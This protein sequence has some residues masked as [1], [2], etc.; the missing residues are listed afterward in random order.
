MAYR[1]PP[2]NSLRAFESAARHMSFKKAAEELN[3]TPA[4]VSHLVKGLEDFLGVRLFRRLTRALEL[5]EAG[6][7]A[8]P[9]IREGF[10]ALAA[11]VERIHSHA[12]LGPLGVSAPPL[13]AT[14]W[15]VP[16]L[17]RFTALHPE[18]ALRISQSE[19]MVDRDGEDGPGGFATPEA[20]DLGAEVAIRFGHGRY[21]G[22]RA[23]RLFPVTYAPV[24]SPQL[25]RSQ[26][27]LRMPADLRFHAL[28]H[29]ETVRNA[30]QWI[31]WEAWLEAA[32][33]TGIDT[34]QGLRF[35]N[36]ALAIEAAEDGLGVA[37][38]VLELLGPDLATGKLVAPF[39]VAVEAGYAYYL[40]CPQAVADRPQVA[41]F[42]E[43]LLEEARKREAVPVAD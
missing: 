39:D 6:R 12:R 16:R 38:G 30:R 37:L 28:I 2:L 32:G 17:Q 9:K 13:F 27:P 24:C 29:D 33:V 11:G 5:T 41:R 34:S 10:E 21:P 8:L 7:A 31:S 3:V 20:S 14:R 42:R 43:W 40:V 19:A 22:W 4:A 15:L 35:T 18:V 1:L 26:R 25:L 36:P 23:D